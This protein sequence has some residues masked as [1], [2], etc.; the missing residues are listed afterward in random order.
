MLPKPILNELSNFLF[1]QN[2]TSQKKVKK[3]YS[4]VKVEHLHEQG[5][6]NEITKVK[7]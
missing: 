4:I 1:S 3:T 5:T 6:Q 7:M 2:P